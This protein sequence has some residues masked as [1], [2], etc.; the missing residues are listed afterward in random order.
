M[1]M[2]NITIEK[3]RDFGEIL[4]DAAVL[5]FKNWKPFLWSMAYLTVPFFILAF[6][7]YF[8]TLKDFSQIAIE[9]AIQMAVLQ[10]LLVFVLFMAA[11]VATQ[12]IVVGLVELYRTTGNFAQDFREV[13]SV[14]KPVLGKVLLITVIMWLLPAILAAAGFLLFTASPVLGG[15][16]IFLLAIIT[17]WYINSIMYATYIGIRYP[18]NAL[19]SIK[20][21]FELVQN[22]W[23]A[24]F[25]FMLLVGIIINAVHSLLFL[26]FTLAEVIK[27]FSAIAEGTTAEPPKTVFTLLMMFQMMVYVVFNGYSTICFNLKYYQ[28]IDNKYGAELENRI[29]DIG[30]TLMDE[31]E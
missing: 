22:Q 25:G 15:I 8:A 4:T 17:I 20:K 31:S 7:L 26:P 18:D 13:W 12:L 10:F 9:D 6:I 23:W 3:P 11:S 16:V 1:E 5:F 29:N 2:N 27:N 19:E 14:L 30:K 28:L 24:A 21:S